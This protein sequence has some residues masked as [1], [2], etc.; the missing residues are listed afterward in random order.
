MSQCRRG[1]LRRGSPEKGI[2]VLSLVPGSG[3]F[4]GLLSRPL[5]HRGLCNRGT[6]RSTL[7]QSRPTPVQFPYMNSPSF[8]YR[9]DVYVVPRGDWSY[10]KRPLIF[11]IFGTLDW[12]S[13]GLC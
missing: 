10:S 3:L 2:V 5:S 4:Q 11:S 6:S 12:Y 1:T 7:P 13:K 9:S 8:E